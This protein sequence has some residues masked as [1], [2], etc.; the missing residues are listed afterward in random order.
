MQSSINC[1]NVE[2]II[3]AFFRLFIMVEVEFSNTTNNG[4]LYFG[5]EGKIKSLWEIF[6]VARVYTR[7]A[8]E[9]FQMLFE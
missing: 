6:S 9:N 5:T 4:H 1:T 8:F 3:M 7:A 2:K